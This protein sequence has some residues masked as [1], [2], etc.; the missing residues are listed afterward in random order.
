MLELAFAG[1]PEFAVPT[2]QALADSRHRLVGVLTQPDRPAGR[3]R[4][5]RSSPVKQL[6][7]Q[8]GLP[9]SSPVSLKSEA[10]RA[11]LASWRPDVLIVAAYGLILPVAALELPARGCINV[12]ASLLPRWRGAAPVQ[13]AILAGDECTGATIMQMNAGL[14]TGPI[15]AQ[16]GFE[17][18][19]RET[20]QDVLDRV[21][22]VG[23]ELLI[24]TLDH[25]EAGT[26]SS[27]EQSTDG[28]T[29]AAKI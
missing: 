4:E 23:A 7:L 29:Y 18:G 14:D 24:E 11:E 6:A 9:V 3:G 1:T 15:L 19:E 20:T 16:R 8:L 27:V 5:L 22:Q 13:R 12:H 25:L 17:I 28:V 10:E 2:L 21:A 26:V